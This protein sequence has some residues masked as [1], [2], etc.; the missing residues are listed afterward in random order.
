MGVANAQDN[1]GQFLFSGFKGGVNPFSV[2]SPAGG[3]PY[4]AGTPAE[5]VPDTDNPYVAYAGD[6]GERI[7]QVDASREMSISASGAEVFMRIKQGNGTFAASADAANLGS[8]KIDQGSV[9]DLSKWNSSAIQPQNFRI[10]FV[11][12]AGVLKYN[13]V[14]AASG[15]ALYPDGPRVFTSGQAIS[16][17]LPGDPTGDLGIQ[18]KIAGNPLA[19]DKFSV[20]ASENQSIFDTFQNIIAAAREPAAGG[21]AGN[22]MLLNR[23]SEGISNLDQALDKVLGVRAAVGSRLAEIESL[24]TASSDQAIQYDQRLSE[25]LELDYASAISDLNKRQIQLEAAQK[26]FARI[27]SLSLFNL[28]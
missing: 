16:F 25:L 24:T 14:D 9:L 26:S 12:D 15:G 19:G 4:S 27:T 17:A 23:V 28:L 21:S 6:D 8:G 5:P 3:A 20:H 2:I 18:V 10:E 7:M 13:I 22:S 11:D 1:L